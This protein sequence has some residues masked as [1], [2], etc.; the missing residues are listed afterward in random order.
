[1]EEYKERGDEHESNFIT[2]YELDY[3]RIEERLKRI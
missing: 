2:D 3:D 1:M